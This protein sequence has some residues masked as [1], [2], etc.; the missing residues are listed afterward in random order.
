ML[1]KTIEYQNFLIFK[2]MGSLLVIIILAMAMTYR[3]FF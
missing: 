2:L 1:R 3:F